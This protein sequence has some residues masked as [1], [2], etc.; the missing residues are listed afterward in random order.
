MFSD[1]TADGDVRAVRYSCT[2]PMPISTSISIWCLSRSI[3]GVGDRP[4][5]AHT[6]GDALCA[7]AHDVYVM[8]RVCPYN[9][10]V[11]GNK[12]VGKHAAQP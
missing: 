7:L 2:S 6:S 3:R 5:T 4:A 8:S 9:V 10:Q 11:E 1:D 12:Q